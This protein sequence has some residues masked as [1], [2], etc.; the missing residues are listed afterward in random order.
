MSD[1]FTLLQWFQRRRPQ[2]FP[3]WSSDFPWHIR[4]APNRSLLATLLLYHMTFVRFLAFVM[5]QF[6]LS[7]SP[8]R[9]HFLRALQQCSSL[10]HQFEDSFLFPVGDHMRYTLTALYCTAGLI[11]K[12]FASPKQRRAETRVAADAAVAK[13]P[14]AVIIFG[15]LRK[16]V[17][18]LQ[19]LATQ[20]TWRNH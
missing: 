1:S 3:S 5:P 13:L 2:L 17:V 8:R 20:I 10:G 11:G 15:R 16:T 9:Q 19:S 14:T 7:S 6:S 12:K 4:S 18:R